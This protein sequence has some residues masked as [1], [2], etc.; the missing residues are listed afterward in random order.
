MVNGMAQY[1]NL[2]FNSIHIPSRAKNKALARQFLVFLY[3]KDNLAALLNSESGL[4]PRVDM[5]APT[6][7]ILLQANEAFKN[8]KGTAQFYD[9]DTDSDMAQVGLNAFQEFS[10]FPERRKA[11]QEKLEEARKRIFKK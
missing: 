11:I 9:R 7:A 6:D 3:R 8:V 1:E 4:S 5:G 10:A 2:A